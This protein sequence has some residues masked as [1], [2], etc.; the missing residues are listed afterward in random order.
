MA[1]GISIGVGADTRPF[2]QGIKSGVITPLEDTVTALGK[3]DRASETAGD[4]L[5]DSMRDAQ[6]ATKELADENRELSQVI[7]DESRKSSR[8]VRDIG[9]DGFD[10]ASEDV[11]EFKKEAVANFSEVASSFN[12]DIT[13]MADGVQG[14]TGGLASALTPGIGIPVAILGAAAGAF[15]AEWQK[16]AE[17]SEQRVA[18]MYDDMVESG[19]EFV[20][21]SFIQDQIKKIGED[22]GKWADALKLA[23]DS[24]VSIQTALRAM[25]GDQDAIT[26]A[27][28]GTNQK[29][30][31][32]LGKLDSLDTSTADYA[33]KVDAVNLK[34]DVTIQ[35]LQ[36][37]QGE[38]DTAAAKAQAVRAAFETGNT[39]LDD[40][41]Q[42]LRDMKDGL[43]KLGP[44][45][46]RVDVIPNMAEFERQ[47]GLQQGRTIQMDV[48]GRITRIGNQTVD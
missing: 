21:E 13:Q 26:A 7:R 36:G 11:D 33:D 30:E 28:D 38:T 27:V 35:K 48:N 2:Q 24:G 37:I 3:V 16:S 29:R 39:V 31:D 12:G 15:L 5:I 34:A 20:S 47:I 32:E 14:L 22:T 41:I 43:D 44:K 9:S 25:A 4:E 1:K 17:Q 42:K 18:D 23:S 8:A 19:A 46:I 45:T 10:R 40:G 6:R